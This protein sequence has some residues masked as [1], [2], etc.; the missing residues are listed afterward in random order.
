MPDNLHISVE[1]RVAT[2]ALARGKVN[3]L[4]E[5]LVD[6]LAACLEQLEADPAVDALI[7]TGQGKFFSFGF[8]IP[9]FMDTPRDD[10][11]RY[12]EKFTALYARLFLF[13]KPVIAALNGHTMAGGCMLASACDWRVMVEGRAKIALNEIGFGSTVL[14][15]AVEMLVY[16]VGA[17]TAQDILYNG[18][19]YTPDEALALGLIDQVCSPEELV[20][21]AQ[22]K[23]TELGAKDTAAFASIKNL[24]RAP[25]AARMAERE[26]ASIAAFVDLWYADSTREQLAKITIN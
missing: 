9:A 13:P 11:T 23:A 6:E 3:A 7:L 24:L 10:F 20:P 16:G 8:D 4:N 15:G 22:A 26:P 21:T 5:S 25:V 18:S 1:G 12:L 14:A 2:V 17:R 19:L